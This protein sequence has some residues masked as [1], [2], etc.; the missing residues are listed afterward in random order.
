MFPMIC[1]PCYML[2][3]SHMFIPLHYWYIAS[4]AYLLILSLACVL[5][6]LIYTV[7]HDKG[8]TK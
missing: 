3:L 4:C 7:L 8:F 5:N 6:A 2:D 1:S